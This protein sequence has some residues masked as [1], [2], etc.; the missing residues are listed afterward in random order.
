[1]EGKVEMENK[2][3]E[4]EDGSYL[5]LTITPENEVQMVLQARHLGER[6]KVTSMCIKLKKEEASDVCEWLTKN[7]QEDAI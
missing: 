3:I 5:E 7:I 6:F 1:M 4:F 2:V